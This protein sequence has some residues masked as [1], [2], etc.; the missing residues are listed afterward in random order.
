MPAGSMAA[1]MAAAGGESNTGSQPSEIPAAA[2]G[3]DGNASGDG[4]APPPSADEQLTGQE[5]AEGGQA[6]TPPQTDIVP[7]T[8]P[9]GSIEDTQ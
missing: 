5:P 3:D 8:E 9:P 2:T 4:E 7:A 6:D 1:G